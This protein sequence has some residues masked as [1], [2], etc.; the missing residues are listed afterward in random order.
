[1][2]RCEKCDHVVEPGTPAQ[3][4]VVQRRPV[5]YPERREP[6]SR[7]PGRQFRDKTVDKGGEGSEIVRE[8]KVCPDCAKSS[9]TAMAG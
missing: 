1:M 9:E 4:V 6:L 2:F 5:E 3:H 8:M 7:R